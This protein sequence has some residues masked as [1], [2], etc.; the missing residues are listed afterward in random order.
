MPSSGYYDYMGGS[1]DVDLNELDNFLNPKKSQ[2]AFSEEPFMGVRDR[3]LGGIMESGDIYAEGGNMAPSY[4]V[5]PYTKR[6]GIQ[7]ILKDSGF[8]DSMMQ[9]EEQVRKEHLQK[10]KDITGV[11]EVEG[12][13]DIMFPVNPEMAKKFE[14]L[15]DEQKLLL[16]SVSSGKMSPDEYFAQQEAI[17]QK[18]LAGIQG[19]IKIV[20]DKKHKLVDKEGNPL[21]K[22]GENYY[23]LASGQK[24]VGLD[25]EGN[26]PNEYIT[27]GGGRGKSGGGGGGTEEPEILTKPDYLLT[28]YEKESKAAEKYTKDAGGNSIPLK[29]ADRPVYEAHNQ[30]A[31]KN[32]LGHL[33]VT[34]KMDTHEAERTA[35]RVLNVA[36]INDANADLIVDNKLNVGRPEVM[37]ALQKAAFE[38][39]TAKDVYAK[40][41][42]LMITKRPKGLTPSG[43][44]ALPD[45][46]NPYPEGMNPPYSGP[47]RR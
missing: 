44:V 3:R 30:K 2:T 29:E 24:Q 41:L 32:Y 1:K 17:S 43:K 37:R 38:G 6:P 33:L 39:L 8:L 22:T 12:E 26:L 9:K 34:Q 13:K 5:S 18:M 25:I 27:T 36:A 7:E 40:I 28:Q 16:Q 20:N 11:K 35:E 14:S 4:S 10:I 42:D 23:S 21:P 47:Q 46:G 19:I 31:T 45:Y 15:P